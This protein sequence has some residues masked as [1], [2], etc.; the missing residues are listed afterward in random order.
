MPRWT[1]RPRR[2]SAALVG[3]RPRRGRKDRE[4]PGHPYLRNL[5]QVG[6]DELGARRTIEGIIKEVDEEDGG[7]REL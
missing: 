5:C 3:L 6:L 2:S 4:A 7:G 1:Y